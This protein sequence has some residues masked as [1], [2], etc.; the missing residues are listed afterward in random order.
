M[1]EF[2]NDAEENG[3]EGEDGGKQRKYE[4]RADKDVD[5]ED[6]ENVQNSG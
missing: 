3:M 6:E 4:G 2:I 5:E 1:F